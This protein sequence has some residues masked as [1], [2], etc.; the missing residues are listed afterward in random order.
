MGIPSRQNVQRTLDQRFVRPHQLNRR[1]VQREASGVLFLMVHGDRDFAPQPPTI[2]AGV[3]HRPCHLPARAAFM[4][5]QPGPVAGFFLAL[6]LWT[7]PAS[8][9]VLALHFLAG[10]LSG[11]KKY[12]H[13]RELKKRAISTLF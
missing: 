10:A 12:T 1:S 8:F 11:S 3:L 2:Q 13:A 5:F 7:F 4:R 9:N 6:R